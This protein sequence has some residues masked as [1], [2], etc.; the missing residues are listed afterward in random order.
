M[1]KVSPPDDYSAFG[2]ASLADDDYGALLYRQ[3]TPGEAMRHANT[4]L[5]FARILGLL[6]RR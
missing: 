5:Y 3:S 6:P 4:S 1:L 2:R